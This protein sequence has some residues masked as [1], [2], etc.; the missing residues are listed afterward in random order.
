MSKVKSRILSFIVGL[1]IGFACIGIHNGCSHQDDG[2]TYTN[3]VVISNEVNAISEIPTNQVN[4]K[5]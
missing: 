3:D 2:K 4:R 1:S 5:T